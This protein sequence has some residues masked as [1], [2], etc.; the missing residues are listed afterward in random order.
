M[1]SMRGISS[2]FLGQKCTQQTLQSTATTVIQCRLMARGRNY[3]I[4]GGSKDTGISAETRDLIANACHAENIEKWQREPGIGEPYTYSQYRENQDDIDDETQQ[5]MIYYPHKGEEPWPKDYVPSPVLLV[6][7]VKPL[8]G[9]P[10][11]HKMDCERIGLG[12]WAPIKKVVALPNLSFYN[13]LLYRIKHL[14]KITPVDFVDDLPPPEEFDPKCAKITHDGKF[15]YH[16]KIGVH[17]D[18]LMAETSD[19]LKVSVD[20]HKAESM[21]NWKYPWQSPMGT[22]NYHRDYTKMNPE[23]SDHI[24]DDS[25]R[26]KY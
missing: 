4:K 23:K 16:S 14:I 7:K 13:A 21:Q 24:T 10:W 11:W 17:S 15:L 8:K 1:L 6:Q 19:E 22:S 18:V 9:E 5:D 25:N 20:T 2:I 12:V 26:V 3:Y